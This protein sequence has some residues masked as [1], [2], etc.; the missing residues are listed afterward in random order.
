[1]NV[2]PGM[3]LG[4]HGDSMHPTIAQDMSR[5]DMGTTAF[6]NLFSDFSTP[7]SVSQLP[8]PDLRGPDMNFYLSPNYPMYPSQPPNQNNPGFEQHHP[9]P[10]LDATWQ[11]FVEQLG[12]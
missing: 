12:F 7:S 2:H 1:M 11:S 9:A 3:F 6:N 10:V 8:V 5:F 4:A